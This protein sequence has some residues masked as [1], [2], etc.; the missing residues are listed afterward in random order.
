MLQISMY[1]PPYLLQGYAVH[2]VD[3]EMV[4]IC[5]FHSYDAA[6][7]SLAVIPCIQCLDILLLGTDNSSDV[8]D[9]G[10]WLIL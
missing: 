1:K 9:N 8:P 2:N 3:I 7:C 6:A 10:M 4:C 5:I